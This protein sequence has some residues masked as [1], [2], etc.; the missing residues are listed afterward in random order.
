MSLPTHLPFFPL[1]HRDENQV[2]PPSP[3]RKRTRVASTRGHQRGRA[4]TQPARTRA[5]P[6]R[7]ASPSSGTSS[8]DSEVED[9][10]VPRIR[11]AETAEAGAT[12]LPTIISA[13]DWATLQ[14][15]ITQARDTSVDA[16]KRDV[17]NTVDVTAGQ[18]SPIVGRPRQRAKGATSR[19]H[20]SSTSTS[21][22]GP[23][24]HVPQ[25]SGPRRESSRSAAKLTA[26]QLRPATLRTLLN[27]LQPTTRRAYQAKWAEYVAY[28][29]GERR[30]M[31]PF[32]A[33]TSTLA[34]FLQ[35]LL[36]RG[37]VYRSL[38]TY[39]AA[40]AFI[41]KL[42]GPK[43][44][45][46]KFVV[47]Q[48]LKGARKAARRSTIRRLPVTRCLLHRLLRAL[49]KVC[50]LEHDKKC[51]RAIFSLAFHA[52]LRPGEVVYAANGQHTLR[53]EQ[54]TLTRTRLDI[55]L[56]SYKHS[57]GRTPT[58][59]LKV[60]TN[61][62]YCPVRALSKYLA[63]RG[64]APGPIFLNAHGAPVTRQDFSRM[65]RGTLAALGLPPN[66]YAP[67]SFRIGR[68]TQ[69]SLDGHLQDTIK[70]VGRWRSDIFH[71]YVRQ[72]VI[73]LPH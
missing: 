33:P 5:K 68:A 21:T 65:L 52:C 39:L 41:F 27:S 1:L 42:N 43:D 26:P 35:S 69:L 38:S 66:D 71:S 73:S 44:P 25:G 62:R 55:L 63:L 60:N 36:T 29:A 20:D 16:S 24:A 50:M 18:T 49:G 9:D 4:R 53:L 57:A 58:L 31:H 72:D 47:T 17:G 48:L 64:T 10:H 61:N 45:T 23:A 15:L 30:G 70:A 32:D 13:E 3:S 67:H 7:Y 40:I 46:R 22:D 59:S 19:R 54:I 37:L 6:A 28:V 14:A 2:I 34:N 11:P 12:S 51:Y 8:G 56:G